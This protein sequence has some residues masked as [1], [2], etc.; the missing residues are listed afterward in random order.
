MPDMMREIMSSSKSLFTVWM[1]SRFLHPV[2]RGIV[3]NRELTGSVC[4]TEDTG[5]FFALYTG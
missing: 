5:Q 3:R 4:I 2:D 1:N